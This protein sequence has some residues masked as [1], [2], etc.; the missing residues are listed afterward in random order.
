MAP[1]GR[2]RRRRRP[3]RAAH[4]CRRIVGVPAPL[5]PCLATQ[6]QALRPNSLPTGARAQV[7]SAGG[8]RIRSAGRPG[9]ADLETQASKSP[10]WT[11]STFRTR[12]HWRKGLGSRPKRDPNERRSFLYFLYYVYFCFFVML[13]L[14]TLR[15]RCTRSSRWVTRLL[16]R[17]T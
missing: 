3:R 8:A 12:D 16:E 13:A 15:S 10:A 2:V 9:G 6:D 14:T 4:R 7:S 5:R 11:G 1:E 17:V